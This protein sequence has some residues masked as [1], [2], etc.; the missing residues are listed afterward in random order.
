M[1]T[2]TNNPALID[3]RAEVGLSIIIVSFVGIVTTLLFIMYGLPAIYKGQDETIK[4]SYNSP[5][6]PQG[7]SLT[8]N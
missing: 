4:F 6:T 5:S 7:S 2:I 1:K 8:A 3:N